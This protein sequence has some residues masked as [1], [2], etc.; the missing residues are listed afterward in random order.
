MEL[1]QEPEPTAEDTAKAKAVLDFVLAILREAIFFAVLLATGWLVGNGEFGWFIPASETVYL[2]F[3]VVGL[4]VSSVSH[5]VAVVVRAYPRRPKQK[6][7]TDTDAP[8]KF[9]PIVLAVGFVAIT[10]LF[11]I[12]FFGFLIVQNAMAV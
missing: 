5:L 7:P 4:F 8:P 10:G 11:M 2:N 1:T 12:L 9:N 6:E 3:L